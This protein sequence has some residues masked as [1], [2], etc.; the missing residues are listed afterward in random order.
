TMLTACND[1]SKSTSTRQMEQR[2]ETRLVPKVT[3]ADRGK[4]SAYEFC[5]RELCDK[6]LAKFPNVID[7]IVKSAQPTPAQEAY[8]NTYISPALKAYMAQAETTNKVLLAGLQAKQDRFATT[9]LNPDQQ[10]LVRFLELTSN[11]KKDPSFE[12][13]FTTKYSNLDFAKAHTTFLTMRGYTYLQKL[14]PDKDIKTALEQ[15]YSLVSVY[16]AQMRTSIGTMVNYTPTDIAEKIKKGEELSLQEVES[17]SANAYSQRMLVFFLF[18]DGSDQINKSL[19]ERPYTAE[20]LSEIYRIHNLPSMVLAKIK[21]P[22]LKEDLCKARY[23]SSINLYPQDQE[24]AK[25]QPIAEQIKQEAIRQLLPNDPAI[26][27]IQ[28]L[29]LI[30]P[31]TLN[32]NSKS[33][34][35]KIKAKQERAVTFQQELNSMSDSAFYTMALIYSLNGPQKDGTC[36]ELP[37]GEISD[38]T[39]PWDSYLALS[40]YSIRY[41]ELGIGI[42]AHELGHSIYAYS[43]N[44]EYVRQCL[45][46][47]KSGIPNYAN[48]DYADIFGAK[49]VAS[50]NKNLK[51]PMYNYVCGIDDP[52][53]TSIDD[54]INDN[55]S[56]TIYRALQVQ[57]VL[58]MDIPQSCQYLVN[59]RTPKA[60]HSC[61]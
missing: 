51:Y 39:T 29:K 24:I 17:F 3:E 53:S 55:H 19:K 44:V 6:T 43:N 9:E 41:P 38:K 2:K 56:G 25:F 10:R 23:L 8:Y 18:S 57:R 37:N 45:I 35:G 13:Y 33:F 47:K 49:V 27:K 60:L 58:G 34:L 46:D 32:Q 59:E 40:W 21:L 26:E 7:T 16:A 54:P 4:Y 15:E 36:D 48:E 1:E 11:L 31:P 61:E 30:Y 14:Y 42:V 20:S 12:S 50:L 28:N 52:K 22:E 5:Y